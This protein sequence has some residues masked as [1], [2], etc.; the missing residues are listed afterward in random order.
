MK[1]IMNAKDIK[2][3]LG[4]SLSLVYTL[5]QDPTFPTIHIGNRKL[6]KAD[7]FMKWLD[8]QKAVI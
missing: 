3:Y 1:P 2:D 5:F 8:T 6:V 7:D 4:I